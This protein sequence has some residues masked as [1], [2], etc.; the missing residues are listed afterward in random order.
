MKINEKGFKILTIDGRCG[1][2]KSTLGKLLSDVYQCPLI[3][4]DDFC[5]PKE[6]RRDEIAGHIDFQRLKDEVY[7]KILILFPR[8]HLN[9]TTLH[10]IILHKYG[11]W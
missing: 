9:L 3:H 4:M 1:S 8:Y 7:K 10:S 6:L 11:L 5:V 2:G